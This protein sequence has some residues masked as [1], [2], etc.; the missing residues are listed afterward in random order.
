[1][2]YSKA[3]A[4]TVICVTL[5][6]RASAPGFGRSTFP[7]R[8]GAA[9]PWAMVERKQSEAAENDE[10][11]RFLEHR[12]QVQPLQRAA[13]GRAMPTA[14]PIV[15]NFMTFSPADAAVRM[16]DGAGWETRRAAILFV[17]WPCPLHAT[18]AITTTRIRVRCFEKQAVSLESRHCRLALIA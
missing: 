18:R 17:D 1:M 12:C 8:C 7:P 13:D 6:T 9:V 2:G 16:T 4:A 5:R 15:M 10:D 11:E 14:V 3:A